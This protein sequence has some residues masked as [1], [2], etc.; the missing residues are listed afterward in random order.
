[1]TGPVLT[2]GNGVIREMARLAALEIPGVMRV[3]RTGPLWRNQ[4]G[5][6]AGSG[7][8][9]RVRDGEVHLKVWIVARPA[10]PLIAVAD[11]VRVA[12]GA[13]VVRLLGLQLGSVRVVVDGVGS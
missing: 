3:A 2:V 13:A 6:S 9:V 10:Q 12:V 7:V 11:D 5:G 1:M 8:R 4:L